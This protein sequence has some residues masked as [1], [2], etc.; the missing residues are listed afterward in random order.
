MAG[1]RRY[2]NS[3]P[4]SIRESHEIVRQV[5]AGEVTPHCQRA[6]TAFR[7]AERYPLWAIG[8]EPMPAGI[9]MG[10]RAPPPPSQRRAAPQRRPPSPKPPRDGRDEDAVLR[11][12]FGELA[13]QARGFFR[14]ASETVDGLT[15][16][17]GG[18]VLGVAATAA[19]PLVI[20]K[21]TR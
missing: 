9:E 7:V 3:T 10:T 16:G 13:P 2:G 1:E 11:V 21:V 15:G 17:R 5:M 20:S 6:Q 14:Q 18:N 8:D 4:E 12:I 19:L